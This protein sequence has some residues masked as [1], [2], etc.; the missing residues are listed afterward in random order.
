MKKSYIKPEITTSVISTVS[1]VCES[2]NV[3]S[4]KA[5]SDSWLGKDRGSRSDNDDNFEDLW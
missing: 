5:G 4:T 2:F 1:M 3:N